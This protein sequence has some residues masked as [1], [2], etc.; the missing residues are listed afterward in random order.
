MAASENAVV[1]LTGGVP[2]RLTGGNLYNRHLCACLE[3]AGV[4]VTVE[5]APP[6]TYPRLAIVDSIAIAQ[7][8]PWIAARP[9]GSVAVAL[10]HML[11]SLHARS[12]EDRF[13]WRRLEMAFLRQVDLVIAASQDLAEW[14]LRVEVPGDRLRMIP[15]GKDGPQPP[16][17]AVERG[18]PGPA[19]GLRLL[20]VA[21][22]FPVKNLEVL[23]QAM[24]DLPPDVQLDLVGDP[25]ADPA[26]EDRV[27][28]AVS[29]YG[30]TD[31]VV[32]H[33]PIPPER[34]GARHASADAFVLPSAFE[35]YATVVAEALW[36]GLPVVASAVGGIPYL[37]T[38]G[39]EGILVPPGRPRPLAEA[40]RR[41]RNDAT[42]R[43]RMAA[44]AGERGQALP[45]W[46]DTR[47][48]LRR[49]LTLLLA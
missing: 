3:T 16:P 4:R 26:Y 6:R 35:G 17:G 36:F 49:L 37:V 27:R 7:G 19:S 23:I 25:A 9:R 11:P 30:L 48:A 10:M 2:D 22:W 45:S 20:C 38:T 40:L 21:N 15:P 44:A 5:T 42:L 47:E 24:S 34:L 28:D 41:L 13:R 33:G 39:V 1:L 12:S 29:R 18:V 32:I 43:R 14:L 46:G 8:F 31:R